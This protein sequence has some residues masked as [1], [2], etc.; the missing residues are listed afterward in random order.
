MSL[1]AN[2]NKQNSKKPWKKPN[3]VNSKENELKDIE[4][5]DHLSDKD[6]KDDDLLND[7]LD[8]EEM[9]IHTVPHQVRKSN[10]IY[11]IAKL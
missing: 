5:S 10:Y 8:M 1:N 4:K 9:E 6:D 3:I 7:D 11:R 2:M